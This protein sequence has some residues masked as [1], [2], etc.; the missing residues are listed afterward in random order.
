MLTII[1][2]MF[3]IMLLVL[4]YIAVGT[5]LN[6][7]ILGIIRREQ[8]IMKEDLERIRAEVAENTSAVDSAVTLIG[9]LSQQIRDNAEDPDA[10]RSLADTLDENSRKLSAAVAANTA[11]DADIDGD[12]DTDDNGDLLPIDDGTGE[13]GEAAG[14]GEGE[15]G[16]GSGGG[17]ATGGDQG[18]AGEGEGGEG[19]EG[20]EQQ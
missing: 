9:S 2:I 5:R 10:L 7:R 16:D 20:G 8:K 13:G 11:G 4:I 15:G 18:G 14:A 17:E 12:V 1:I 19:G 3:A 6:A